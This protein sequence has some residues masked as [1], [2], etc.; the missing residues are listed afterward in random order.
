MVNFTHAPALRR[1]ETC[2][3]CSRS[4]WCCTAEVSSDVIDRTT[5]SWSRTVGEH[6]EV[7]SVFM[8]FVDFPKISSRSFE[9]LCRRQRPGR[10]PFGRRTGL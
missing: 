4:R 3:V 2:A 10:G 8:V 9:R 7:G 6:D 1:P 5:Y